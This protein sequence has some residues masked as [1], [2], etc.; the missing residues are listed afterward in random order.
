MFF[1]PK[2]HSDVDAT[3]QTNSHTDHPT[4][5]QALI[6][7]Y[8]VRINQL[9]E[10]LQSTREQLAEY[11]KFQGDLSDSLNE[12]L[13][14]QKASEI[15]TAHL[16]YDK[17]VTSLLQLCKQVI[18]ITT[19]NV[20]LLRGNDWEPV[21]DM[22][23]D[24]FQ[25]IFDNLLS[26]GIIDWLLT[27]SQSIVIPLEELMVYEELKHKEGNLVL[28]P[29]QVSSKPIGVLMLLSSQPQEDFT[30]RD[31]QLV[32]ILALQAAVSIQYTRMYKN[33]ESTHKELEHSQASLLQAVKLATVGEVAGGVA[34]EI[35]NPLQIILGK[36][37]IARTGRKIPE[38]LDVIEMQAMRIANIVRGLLTLSR[39]DLSQRSEPIYI[40]QVIQETTNLIR[41]QV[42]KRGIQI[43]LH[44]SDSL[45]VIKG[46][47]VYWQQIFLNFILNAKKRMPSGGQLNIN[48]TVN[49][50]RDEIQVVFHDTGLP[51]PA[52]IQKNL[53][54]PFA[55]QESSLENDAHFGLMMSAQMILEAGGSLEVESETADGNRIVIRIPVEN[56]KK[57]AKTY[58]R[59]AISW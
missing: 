32:S 18:D 48:T 31:L 57:R 54:H 59:T 33:L 56:V 52:E 8:T 5:V 23:N 42:E 44:F 47:F 16:D 51:F 17:I 20:Y 21:C 49:Q 28:T 2:N 10:E 13:T 40:K 9:Q 50:E 43:N 22:A 35:N 4:P 55:H 27:Q 34:H 6:E 7:E 25:I 46:N 36:I 3:A 1:R 58:D 53:S 41:S 15:I 37:Q 11:R 24:D 39:Q 30:R 12:I 38:A 14:I 29:L 19:G 26:E 45:P